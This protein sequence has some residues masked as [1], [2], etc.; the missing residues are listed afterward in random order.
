MNEI[1]IGEKTYVSSKRAAEITGYAKDYIGQLCREGRVEARLI[2]RNWYLLDE[3]IRKHRFGEQEFVGKSEDTAVV[4]GI[5]AVDALW[6]SPRYESEEP[7]PLEVGTEEAYSAPKAQN[8][9]Q[10]SEFLSD[11]Q[12]AWSEWFASKATQQETPMVSKIDENAEPVANIRHV[13]EPNESDEAHIQE[14]VKVAGE[15]VPLKILQENSHESQNSEENTENERA[16]EAYIHSYPVR[17]SGYPAMLGVRIALIIIAFGAIS[18]AV[19]G[20]GFVKIPSSVLNEAAVARYITGS[21][22]LVK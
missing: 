13:T 22:I 10:T 19:F 20:T 8:G 15:E 14:R 1:T 21:N 18:T 11:M 2:G 7:K 17:S 6:E 12:T 4:D 9:P 5:P 3:S 16:E